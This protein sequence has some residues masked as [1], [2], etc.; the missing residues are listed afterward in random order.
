MKR[1]SPCA[2]LCA[3]GM[4]VL[5]APAWCQD[6]P[7]KP[8]RILVGYQPGG[9]ADLVSR[10]VAKGLS[11]KF[12]QSVIV[13]N[14]SGAGG[15]IANDIVAKSPPDGYTL[16]L[17][18]SSF[19]Y[20][21]AMFSNKKLD[22][23]V[24]KDYV[25]VAL[26]ATTQNLLATNLAVQANSVKELIALAKASPGKLSYASGGIGGSTHLSTELFKSMTGTDMVHIAYK[27]N[28]PS[29]TDLISGQVD[30]TIAPLPALL[31][32]VT[33]GKLR[34]LGT[35]GTKRSPLFPNLPTIAEAGVPGYD[36]GSWY[37]Y[38]APA[39]TPPAV[40]A[41]LGSEMTGLLNNQKFV[42]QLQLTIGAESSGMLSEKFAAFI[43]SETD[44]W[45]KVIRATGIKGE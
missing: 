1:F 28:G 37:G 35:S 33:A 8:V 10:L 42:D 30:V 14:R 6:F 40:I 34:A 38:M 11:E 31:P 19:A 5:A 43:S 17:A 7:T 12:A 32:F 24:K 9:A 16:L 2:A 41:R 4:T 45:G 29:I 13:D 21:P 18:N 36:A 39:K 44:K 3:A 26:V 22:F 27:G 23:D 20:I 15:F 25:A